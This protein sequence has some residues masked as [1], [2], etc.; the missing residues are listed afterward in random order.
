MKKVLLSV[1]FI[2]LMTLAVFAYETVIIKYPEDEHWV[3]VYYK[4]V[5]NEAIAQY[6]PHG[7]S[8][9]NWKRSIVI[10]SYKQP[11]YTVKVFVSN[12]LTRMEKNNRTSKYKIVRQTDNDIIA[13]RCTEIY[14]NISAQCEIFRG[15]YAHEGII[16]IHYINKDKKD[17][18]N[19]YKQW[20]EIIKGA[21]LYNSYYR[22]E[23]TLDKS[24][25]CEFY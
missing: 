21:K 11:N 8:Q 24:E 23:R 9:T 10:H 12:S 25:Y 3:K 17:F 14:N 18:I 16:S 15:T 22:D 20:Y 19:N 2:L 1:S 5:G 7:Q 13:A 4:K 6:V